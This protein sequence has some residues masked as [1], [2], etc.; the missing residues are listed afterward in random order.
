MHGNILNMFDYW[1]D[2]VVNFLL[3]KKEF[4]GVGQWL[5]LSW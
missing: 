1:P 4:Y 5:W 3:P 2:P